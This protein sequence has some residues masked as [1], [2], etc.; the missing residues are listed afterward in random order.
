MASFSFNGID[1]I[2]ASFAELAEMDEETRE[3]LLRA[4]GEAI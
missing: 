4:G 3:K 2:S 1:S